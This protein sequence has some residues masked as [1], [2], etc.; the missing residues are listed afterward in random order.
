MGE[1]AHGKRRTV[2]RRET[3]DVTVKIRKPSLAPPLTHVR[4]ESG[5]SGVRPQLLVPGEGQQF[6][7]LDQ[8]G[9]ALALCSGDGYLLGASLSAKELLAR[10]GI[11]TSRLPRALPSE[12][13]ALCSESVPG[14]TTVYQPGGAQSIQLAVTRYEYAH[15]QVLLMLGEVHD[16]QQVL[17]ARLHQQ[18]L[19]LTG[20]LVAM[21][22]HDL[23]VPL[24]TILF[25]AEMACGVEG[26]S[27]DMR[28][29]LEDVRRAASRMRT[30]FDHLLDFARPGGSRC[31]PVDLSAVLERLRSLLHPSLRDGDHELRFQLDADAVWV[32]TN[33]LL[34]E[35]VLA[36]LVM[37][38]VEAARRPTVIRIESRLAVGKIGQVHLTVQDDGP[39]VPHALRE[40]VFEP[41]FTTKQRGTGLGLPM[42]REALASLG[43]ELRLEPSDVGARFGMLL[44]V[45]APSGVGEDQ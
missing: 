34:L 42:A 30:A 28:V 18:R 4:R 24:S 44:P 22:A 36:N 1:G 17:S 11:A 10:A 12:L 25:N 33:A 5:Q 14:C 2:R 29:L 8:V 39:G 15:T 35:H 43:G 23:R 21:I 9:S 40:R 41:F 13:W 16:K 45:A 37:N 32:D 6:L 31:T 27:D 3:R 7:Q 26:A 38:A 19:E 20:R